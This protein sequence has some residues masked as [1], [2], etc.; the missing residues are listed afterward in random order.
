MTFLLIYSESL[1]RCTTLDHVKRAGTPAPPFMVGQASPCL[2]KRK[3]LYD[4]LGAPS[5]RALNIVQR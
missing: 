5:V 3:F 1:F 4:G 2:S